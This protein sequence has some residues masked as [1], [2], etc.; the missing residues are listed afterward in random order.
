M[1]SLSN[2]SGI[3]TDASVLMTIMVA[4]L[5]V[6]FMVLAVIQI[7][8]ISRQVVFVAQNHDCRGEEENWVGQEHQFDIFVGSVATGKWV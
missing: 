2:I 8:T 1:A 7:I 6:N 4:S 5:Q 3:H